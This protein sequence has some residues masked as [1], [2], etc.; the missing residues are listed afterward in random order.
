M[1]TI[2]IM[3]SL[4]HQKKEK[5][6]MEVFSFQERLLQRAHMADFPVCEKLKMMKIIH[7]N[8][9]EHFS[10]KLS[11]AGNAT[12]LLAH[13]RADRL[14]RNMGRFINDVID[15]YLEILQVYCHNINMP[16][17]EDFQKAVLTKKVEVVESHYP[18]EKALVIMTN[19]NENEID[20]EFFTSNNI[21]LSKCSR[22]LI[23][24]VPGEVLH[25]DFILNMMD[26]QR[27]SFPEA[28][29][30][31]RAVFLKDIDNDDIVFRSPY[32]SYDTVL[33]FMYECVKDEDLN[34]IFMTI[35]R[36]DSPESEIVKLLCE[37]A[38][39]Y[40]K[41]VIVYVECTAKGNEEDNAKI[42]KLLQENNVKAFIGCDYKVHAKMFIALSSKSG[43]MYGHFSTGNYNLKTVGAYTDIQLIT[44]DPSKIIP[45]I[46]IF[47]D[48]IIKL[49]F[50][51]TIDHGTKPNLEDK[52]SI[53][54]SPK[55]LKNMMIGLIYQ[56]I[57]KGTKGNIVIKVNS[58][59]DP[60]IIAHL[61]TA[62]E[63]GVNVRLIVRSICLMEASYHRN[64]RIE[65][66][67]GRYLEHDRI[68]IF[69]S[70]TFIASADLSF[71]NM[72]KRIEY[73]AEITNEKDK[74]YIM[75]EIY[76]LYYRNG[77]VSFKQKHVI[78]G[79]HGWVTCCNYETL[80]KAY[81]SVSKKPFMP[82]TF[83]MPC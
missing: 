25:I 8:V 19:Y 55:D 82:E 47:C 78:L 37:A 62:V 81:D 46:N 15:E 52:A 22:Y 3:K 53:W 57:G 54:F 59:A 39:K 20:D 9:K 5:V 34:I 50:G 51:L 27:F 1:D 65:S 12:N 23:I 83:N 35:Y 80:E 24:N 14:Y 69:G 41:S 60:E 58:L 79:D 74:E 26:V 38:T 56:E 67:C 48:K 45:A 7:N 2:Q 28:V 49:P 32:E 16:H 76:R 61:Y 68:Y 73:L 33:D 75:D 44:S 30:D 13:E 21:D 29:C 64:F 36:T 6:L 72:H 4:N 40:K 43:R 10:M 63:A 17:R 70:R 71:R 42:V 31:S 66:Y 77:Y 18:T 11:K